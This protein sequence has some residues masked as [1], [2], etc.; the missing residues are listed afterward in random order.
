LALALCEDLP[1][2]VGRE[3]PNQELRRVPEVEVQITYGNGI[4]NILPILLESEVL[5]WTWRILVRYAGFQVYTTRYREGRVLKY[6][7]I[8][9][10]WSGSGDCLP[11]DRIRSL[12]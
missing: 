10:V 8:T 7:Y 2:W 11:A 5:K 12:P 3:V 4:F 1:C 9:D 6:I